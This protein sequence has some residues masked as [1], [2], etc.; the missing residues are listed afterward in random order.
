MNTSSLIGAIHVF[1]AWESG[2]IKK[3]N[4]TV[5]AERVSQVVLERGIE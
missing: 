1:N 5:P 2:I 4:T 3:K